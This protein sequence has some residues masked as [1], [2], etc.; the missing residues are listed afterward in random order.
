[1][2]LG[3]WCLIAGAIISAAADA[4]TAQSRRPFTLVSL[5]EVPRLQDVQLA[6]DGRF[7]S[8]ALAKADWK[9]NRLVTHIWTQATDGGSPTQ[10]TSTEAG[11]SFARWSPDSRALLFLARGEVGQQIFL[12]PADGGTPRA[13]TRHATSVYAGAPPAWSPDGTSIYFLASDPPTDVERDR[14]RLR[15]DLYLFEENYKPRHLWSVDV[16]TGAER[17]LTDGTTSASSFRV[18]RDGTMIAIVRAPTPLA[19]DASQG[20]VWVMDRAGKKVRALTNNAV[21][22][23]DVELSPDN[24]RV[25]FLADANERLE[26]YYN[27]TLFIADAREHAS[28]KPA[29]VLPNFPHTFERAAWADDRTIVAVVNMGVHS[30]IVRIDVSGRTAKPL[31]D[32]RHSIQFWSVA[33]AAE[34]MVFQLDEPTRIGD[35]WTLPVGG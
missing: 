15:D 2:H 31:T 14:E 3:R 13:L 16:A 33:A 9:A 35:A 24:T 17:K 5:A 18:S 30:E 27:A 28:S 32:G 12:I 22:E 11:E 25:L 7:V 8:Y 19:G 4:P 10:I 34:R 21:E 1:M 26:P 29:L 23:F 20:E 6:P